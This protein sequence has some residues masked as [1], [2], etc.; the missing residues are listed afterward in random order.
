MVP[1]LRQAK[2]SEDSV[3]IVRNGKAT[4]SES[5][6]PPLECGDV[7][8]YQAVNP[9]VWEDE[10]SRPVPW[11][12]VAV[13]AG[14]VTLACIGLFAPPQAQFVVSTVIVFVGAAALLKLL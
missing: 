14:I 3:S 1:K 2:E 12:H 5:I 7:S 13:F 8:R 6:V 9:D 11:K 10:P 4:R